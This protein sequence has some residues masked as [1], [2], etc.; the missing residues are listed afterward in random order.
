MKDRYFIED[1]FQYVKYGNNL[2]EKPISNDYFLDERIL[3]RRIVSRQ[4]RVM[5][6]LAFDGFVNK[7]DIYIL[8]I[9]SPDFVAKYVLAILNSRLISF[10]KTR[11]SNSAKKDDFTQLTLNEIREIKIPKIEEKDQQPFVAL[12]DQILELKKAGKDTQ[13]L[14]DEIDTLVY[15]LYDLTAEEIAIVEGK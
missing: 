10:L 8:K 3:I 14:E 5:C 1:K 11:S 9:C 4:F 6:S 15:R 13:A 7:K 12:V 2:K